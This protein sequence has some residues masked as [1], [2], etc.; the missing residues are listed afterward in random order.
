MEWEL[1]EGLPFVY[2]VWVLRRDV[3]LAA[4]KAALRRAAAH[5]I[6]ALPQLIDSR[7]EYDAAFRRRYLGDCIHFNVDAAARAGVCR[8][9]DRLRALEGPPVFPPHWVD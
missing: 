3:G 9:V 8:F 4:T 6:S 1:Q 2:A 7:P 5:G